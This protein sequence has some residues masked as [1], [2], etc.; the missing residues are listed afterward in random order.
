MKK[1]AYYFSHD[2]NS[3]DDPKC[4]LLIE[5]L[6]LEG[7]GIFWVLLET[8][9]EQIDFK[10]PIA[11][12]PAIS[13]RYNTSFE[14]VK[15]VVYNYS[16]FIVEDEQFFYSKSLIE[17]M[18]YLKESREKRKL[19]G[20]LGNKIRWGEIAMRSQCDDNAIAMQSQSL[21]S[22]VKESKEEYILIFDNFRKK[23]IGKKRGLETEFN[24]FRKK[25]KDIDKVINI[26]EPALLGQIKE[27]DKLISLKK[28]V[29][30]WPNLQTWINQRRWEVEI[31]NNVSVEEQHKPQMF[32]I[33]PFTNEK[34]IIKNE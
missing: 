28:W 9:R 18:L 16:L 13:R 17:R 14:K 21:A 8:L 7:Y 4:V 20:E 23:Y 1:D 5:Q 6:G 11:L 27:R 32:Y 2:S 33:D 10:Y 12:L 19:A 24:N 25:T 15:T 31:N 29:P 3:K 34:K 22:K 26:L 30:E